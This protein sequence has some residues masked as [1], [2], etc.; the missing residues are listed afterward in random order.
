MTAKRISFVAHAGAFCD[1]TGQ[2]GCTG[3]IVDLAKHLTQHVDAIVSGH[4]HTLVN[5][6]VNGV[7]ILQGR[8]SGQ[9]IDVID[10]PIGPNAS[11]M[12]AHEVRDVLPDSSTPDPGIQAIVASATQAVAARVSRPIARIAEYMKKSPAGAEEQVPL[13]NL[14]ADAMRV[15]G[16]GDIGM[17]N[18]G[19]IRAALR[20]GTATYGDLFEVQPFGNILYRVTLDG[21][22]LRWVELPVVGSEL[23]DVGVRRLGKSGKEPARVDGFVSLGV[24]GS[25]AVVALGAKVA[26]PLI[27]LAITALILR[28]TWQAWRTVSAEHDDRNH[29]N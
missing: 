7:P 2:S 23:D 15:E 28:I 29:S 26:D 5:S 11:G 10:I 22:S 3:E 12:P 4:T 14:I 8:S 6:V 17:M 25:A 20:A 9:A 18:N 1:R 21:R 16:K 19:G 24:I 13:G 27:G